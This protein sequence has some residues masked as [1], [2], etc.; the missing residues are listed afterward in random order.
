M[1]PSSPQPVGDHRR[2]R[3]VFVLC[4][5][6]L[7]G[8][9]L[10]KLLESRRP[11]ADATPDAV[12]APSFARPASAQA[13]PPAHRP[14]AASSAEAL[15]ADRTA[16]TSEATADLSASAGDSASTDT[17]ALDLL[18]ADTEPESAATEIT[19]VLLRVLEQGTRIPIPNVT[20]RLRPLARD[21]RPFEHRT[22]AAGLASFHNV[23]PGRYEV[24]VRWG[25]RPPQGDDDITV[26]EGRRTEHT[27]LLPERPEW[28]ARLVDVNGD[29]VPGHD[30]RVGSSVFEWFD[31]GNVLHEN[32]RTDNQ[33]FFTVR[34]YPDARPLHIESAGANLY[35][36][37]PASDRWRNPLADPRPFEATGNEP[38]VYVLRTDVVMATGILVNAPR[39]EEGFLA[40]VRAPQFT[41]WGL[42]VE[43]DRFTFRATTGQ[44]TRITLARRTAADLGWRGFSRDL[45][46]HVTMPDTPGPFEFEIPFPERILVRGVVLQ[47]D[48]RGAPNVRVRAN[49]FAEAG[50]ARR[51]LEAQRT[52][53]VPG[54]LGEQRRRA[55][56]NSLR[57]QGDSSLLTPPTARDGRFELELVPATEYLFTAESQTLT[58][59]HKGYE[60]AVHGWDELVAGREVVL[61]LQT[62]SLVW[63]EVVDGSNRPAPGVRVLLQGPAST[64]NAADYDARTDEAGIFEMNVPPIRGAGIV[65]GLLVTAQSNDRF[66]IAPA[67]VDSSSPTRVILR[68]AV[69]GTFVVTRGGL[70]VPRV[71]IASF[72]LE[73]HFPGPIVRRAPRVYEQANGHYTFR[74]VPARST[75]YS[76]VEP[77]LPPDLGATVQVP[78]N[79]GRDGRIRVELPPLP[80]VPAPGN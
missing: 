19:G 55:L 36:I 30:L 33:G 37:D 57:W 72:Y 20:A 43:N 5:L 25:N 64:F 32:V 23:P 77:G 17:L 40:T 65:D 10:M 26:A 45:E 42:P 27:V 78:T 29:P 49:A 67:L 3:V 56:A 73:D 54:G 18:P 12:T 44:A 52:T 58:N 80:E 48:G 28:R 46:H 7:G 16:D 9:S 66:G 61:R 70:P 71:E 39:T 69:S 4:V 8:I 53:R 35:S 34:A 59:D 31:R 24:I 50:A 79:P 60:A 1:S 15:A 11:V 14:A 76:F 63:G 75:W 21:E 74:A 22:N 2:A 62:S 13:L 41:Y 47:P 6:A 68:P 51:A 38:R